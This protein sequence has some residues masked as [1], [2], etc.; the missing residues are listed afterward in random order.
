M[1]SLREILFGPAKPLREK[2]AEA[3]SPAD[4]PLLKDNKAQKSEET[5]ITTPDGQALQSTGMLKTTKTKPLRKLEGSFT[6]TNYDPYDVNQNR[7]DA[8]DDNVGIGAAGVKIGESMVAVSRKTDSD[9]AMVRLG[10]VLRD[11]ETKEM[12]LVADLMNRRFDGQNKIDF[13]TPKKG[14]EIDEKY[15]RSFEGLEIVREG[16]GYEDVR[17]FVESGEWERMRKEG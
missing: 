7:P 13:A 1:K 11:P 15:N 6:G 14:K 16:Q 8:T 10:T 5:P 3:S 4:V 9:E 2:L 17:K 12:Y